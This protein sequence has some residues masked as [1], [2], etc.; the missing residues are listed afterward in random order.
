M[1]KRFHRYPV[2][3]IA[4]LVC[5]GLQAPPLQAQFDPEAMT[6]PLNCARQ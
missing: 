3:L 2:L 5:I 1:L 4:L 6:S